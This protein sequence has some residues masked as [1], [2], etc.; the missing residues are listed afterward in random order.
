MIEAFDEARRSPLAD[1]LDA[2]TVEF[3]YAE[4][5]GEKLDADE[6]ERRNARAIIFMREVLRWVTEPYSARAIFVRTVAL[7][8]VVNP[9]VWEDTPSLTE[10]ARRYRVPQPTLVK[11]VLKAARHFGIRNRAMRIR[12]RKVVSA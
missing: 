1:P 7:A 9:S 2:I 4:L 6:A 3:P 11:G 10:L 12:L 8:W 5:E